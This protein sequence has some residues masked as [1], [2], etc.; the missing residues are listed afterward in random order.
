MQRRTFLQGSIAA[1]QPLEG[2]RDAF[3]EAENGPYPMKI[4]AVSLES[5]VRRADGERVPLEAVRDIAKFARG[6][7]L[8]PSA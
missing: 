3:D 2:V 1:T 7:R 5:P 4:G 8:R 6:A